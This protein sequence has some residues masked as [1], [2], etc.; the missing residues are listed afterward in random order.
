MFCVDDIFSQLRNEIRAPALHQV[1]A[2]Q[3]VAFLG[4]AVIESFLRDAAAQNLRI[5]GF[6]NDN[7]GF[8]APFL[9]N[10]RH[11]FERTP[12]AE[13]RHPIVELAVNESLENF[14]GGRARMRVGIGFV[15]ELTHEEPVVL[16]G[17]FFSFGYHAAALEF[18]R[19]EHDFCAQEACP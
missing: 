2:K 17:E 6:T 1:R 15:F 19:C 13:T 12:C 10:P 16:F 5:V 7:P 18:R 3:W 4:R 11:T 8:R 14:R 9:E